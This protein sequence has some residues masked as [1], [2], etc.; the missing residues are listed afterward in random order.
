MSITGGA[1]GERDGAG[2]GA[3][4]GRSRELHHPAG[5]R[6]ADQ[7][8]V[9]GRD[10][11]PDPRGRHRRGV[12]PRHAGRRA[13][14][15][16]LQHRRHGDQP[17]RAGRHGARI[18]ARRADQFDK[19]ETGGRADLRQLPDRQHAAGA[20]VRRAVSAVSRAGVADHQRGARRRRACRWSRGRTHGD[21]HALGRHLDRWR[22]RPPRGLRS[23]TR[24]CGCNARISLGGQGPAG[25]AVERARRAPDH[26]RRRACR[27]ARRRRGDR[28]G[29]GSGADASAASLRPR[30]P[31]ARC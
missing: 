8:P 15:R 18:P 3:R 16:C 31:P 4:L 29:I 24:R 2:Q 11:L 9:Q 25:A 13:E 19:H 1:A 27:A 26:H 14:A 5:A 17:G 12:R 23:A 22:R 20:G 30:S 6:Q 21:G 28:A 7:L 10:A